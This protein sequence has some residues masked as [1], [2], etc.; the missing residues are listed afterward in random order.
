VVSRAQAVGGLWVVRAKSPDFRRSGEDNV[1]LSY[2][3]LS[4][5]PIWALNF[6]RA[7]EPGVLRAVGMTP[8]RVEVAS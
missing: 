6:E 7:R 2:T 5:M 3:I 1:A 8:R 4:R